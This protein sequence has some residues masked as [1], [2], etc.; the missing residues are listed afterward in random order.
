[1]HG[2]ALVLRKSSMRC[3]VTKL[4]WSALP[5][6]ALRRLAEMLISCPKA[7]GGRLQLQVSLRFGLFLCYPVRFLVTLQVSSCNPCSFFAGPENP[8]FLL[9]S[10]GPPSSH[11]LQVALDSTEQDAHTDSAVGAPAMLCTAGSRCRGLLQGQ[12]VTCPA[13]DCVDTSFGLRPVTDC[14]CCSCWD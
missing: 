10:L 6:P 3:V 7:P 9:A 13:S 2:D 11:R 1:M 8:K 12:S 14:M 4:A 5:C